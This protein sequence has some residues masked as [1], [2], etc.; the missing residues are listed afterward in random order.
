MAP[1]SIASAD[2]FLQFS[3]LSCVMS[4]FLR[5]PIA[6]NSA[7]KSMSFCADPVCTSFQLVL[8]GLGV[9]VGPSSTIDSPDETSSSDF[10]LSARGEEIPKM[11]AK[12]ISP[13]LLPP[14]DVG[15]VIKLPADTLEPACVPIQAETVGFTVVCSFFGRDFGFTA[16]SLMLPSLVL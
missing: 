9:A 5:I 7:M 1:L 13:F 10:L 12:P 8:P 6:S 15:Q 4:V 2:H 14:L 16:P 3:H 11:H